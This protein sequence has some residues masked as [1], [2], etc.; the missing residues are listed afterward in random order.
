M[1]LHRFMSAAEY[2]AYSRGETLHN[3]TIH[4]ENGSRSTSVGFCFFPEDPDDAKH[5]LSSLVDMDVCLTVDVPGELITEANR[6]KGRYADY[7]S[8]D[9]NASVIRREYCFREYDRERFREVEASTAFADYDM[10]FSKLLKFLNRA[11]V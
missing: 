2:E 9:F 7:S 10:P 6:A 4:R 8:D 1:I 3:N 11:V 5:W